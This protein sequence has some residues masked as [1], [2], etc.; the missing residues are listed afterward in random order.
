MRNSKS[1]LAWSMG[2]LIAASVVLLTAGCQ[3]ASESKS[4]SAPAATAAP[5][6]AAPAPAAAPAAAAPATAPK[7]ATGAMLA[8]PVH[9]LAGVA[10]GFTDSQGNKWIG[11]GT[12][13]ADAQTI[14]RAGIPIAGVSAADAHI[15]QSEAYS[16]SKFS[17]GPIP[18]GNYTV[19]LHFCETY[20]GITAAG[21]RVFTYSVGDHTV[22]HFDPFAKAGFEKPYIDT[23]PVTVKNNKIEVT[24]T[25]ET[26]NPQI[27]GI[28]I[29]PAN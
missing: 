13:F 16:M 24:F 12:Y 3:S 4:G 14:E 7:P 10:D 11:N 9:I 28:E 2:G 15:Y 19:K 6:P 27:N 5:K 22:Q 21:G 29:L 26:E 1:S 17:Y 20:D 18:N 25:A 23:V 8:V